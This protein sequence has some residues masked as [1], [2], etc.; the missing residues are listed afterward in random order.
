MLYR[1]Y[2]TTQYIERQLTAGKRIRDVASAIH[3][4][5]VFGYRGCNTEH[6]SPASWSLQ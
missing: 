3:V 4:T 2:I 5:V 6:I 1:G